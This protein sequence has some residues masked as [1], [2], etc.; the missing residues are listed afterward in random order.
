MD[1]HIQD[2]IEGQGKCRVVAEQ[3]PKLRVQPIVQGIGVVFHV[4]GPAFGIAAETEKL[5]YVVV[6]AAVKVQGLVHVSGITFVGQGGVQV[7]GGI[8]ASVVDVDGIILG[9]VNG[10]GQVKG[11]A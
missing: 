11:R 6:I 5:P 9:T 3:F 8:G 10:H 2:G 7:P 1:V 4:S